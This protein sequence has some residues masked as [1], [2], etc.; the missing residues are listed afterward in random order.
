MAPALVPELAVSDWQRSRAFY[1]DL[2]GFD[3][4][5]DRPE[6]GFA[7]LALGD[8]HLMIDQ[9]GVGRTFDNGHA[10]QE[11]PFGRGLNLQ[12]EVEDV[13]R[14]LTAL[15]AADWPLFLPLEEKWYR[16]GAGETGNRQFVVAD[17]DGYLLRFY[18]DLGTRP[19]G[20]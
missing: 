20:G 2:L 18:Q 5:Y 13:D 16:Q 14:L 17:P 3:C 9:I 8:A 6:E 4:L 15:A 11:P 1:C 19:A 10:P 12:I 7:Y